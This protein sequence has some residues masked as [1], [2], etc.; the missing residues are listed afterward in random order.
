MAHAYFVQRY[1]LA[2]AMIM[3]LM[4]RPEPLPVEEPGEHDADPG[5][6]EPDG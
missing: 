5:M 1:P 4:R 3:G 6:P 2:A